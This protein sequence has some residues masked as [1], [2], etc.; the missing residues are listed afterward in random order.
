VTT[1]EV[2]QMA[3]ALITSFGSAGAVLW[4]L[5]HFLGK[6]WANRI[7]ESD[8]AKYQKL[9]DEARTELDRT[10]RKVQAGLDHAVYVSRAQ[11][12]AEFGRSA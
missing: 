11:F 5:S 10:T 1:N 7:F 3:G 4:G 9:I 12:E 6:V 8:R 2:W